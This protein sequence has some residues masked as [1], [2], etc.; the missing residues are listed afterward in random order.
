VESFVL[1]GILLFFVFVFVF[2]FCLELTQYKTV[3]SMAKN[4]RPW[5]F[6]TSNIFAQIDAFV[7]RCR[8]LLEVCEGQVQFSRKNRSKVFLN[9]S[10]FLK[11]D[12]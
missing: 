6:E 10:L 8:D 2:V 3:E 11:S 12:Y 7:Q 1:K 9:S 5:G 4:P